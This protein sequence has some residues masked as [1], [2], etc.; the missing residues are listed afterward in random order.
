MATPDYDDDRPRP[1]AF[2]EAAKREGWGKLK[3]FLGA[4]PGVGKTYAM[5]E[6]AQVRRKEGVDLVVGVVETH[7]RAET[8]VLLQGLEVLPR[9]QLSYRGKI[10]GEMDLDALLKRKPKLALVD[11]LAHSNVPGSR[12][13]K[14]HQDVEELLAAGIDVYT[15]LNIQHLESLNDVVARIARIRVRETLPDKVLELADEIELI[16]LPPDD[17]LQRLREGKVYVRDQVGHAIRHFFSKGNLTAFRELSLRVAAERVDA[18]MLRYMRANAIPGPWPAQDRLLVCVNEAEVSKSL[19]RAARR[20]AERQRMPW[21]AIY[22]ETLDYPALSDELKGRIAAVLRLAEN[23]GG[24]TSTIHTGGRVADELL[25]YA[26]TRNISHILIGRPRRRKWPGWLRESVGDTILRTG[27]AFEITVIS[28]DREPEPIRAPA[29][30]AFKFRPHFG[31][32]G[33]AALAVF[34][35]S[36]LAFIADQYLPVANVALIYLAAVLV[37][38][39]RQGLG[40]S[41]FAGVLSFMICDYF[42]TDPRYTLTVNRKDE[43]LTLFLFLV[44]ATLAGDLA[45]RLKDQVEA[46]RQSTR[47]ITNLYDFSR[48]IAAAAT[49]DDVLWTS[50]HHVAST[51]R[52]RS[53][54]LLPNPEGRLGIV[55]GFPPEDQLE[56]KDWGAAEWAWEHQHPAGWDTETLPTANW[57]FYPFKTRRGYVG[58]LGISFDKRQRHSL[59]ED[60]FR[61]LEAIIDQMAIATERAR[62]VADLE[63]ARLASETEQLRSALL[64]SVSHDLRTPLVSMIGAATSLATY[65][66]VLAK[67]DHDQLVQTILDE[68]ERLNRNVQNLLDMTRLG[69]GSLELK[70][71]WTDP[72]VLAERAVK[73]L[74]TALERHKLVFDFAPGL[75]ALHVDMALITQVLVNLLEN[76][77]KFAPAATTITVAAHADPTEMVITVSDEGPGIPVEARDAAFDMF[78]RVRPSDRQGGTGLGLSICRGLVQAHGGH[79]L[80]KAGPN[81]RGTTIEFTLPLASPPAEA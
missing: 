42:F 37:V 41:I 9:R 20:M 71:E 62:L 50:V 21:V 34:Y 17:L 55:S 44:V 54:I 7:G 63:E 43:L 67:G 77:A 59:S 79:I 31:A 53:I 27:K 14:R 48:R 29:R 10:F 60:Q 1:E 33:K 52:C 69:Y 49:L 75:P 56:T 2:L 15:T 23:L 61:L 47:R 38:G 76:A 57:Y 58:L 70:R 65:G 39:A 13:T 11:E 80:A 73:Q 16:D 3:I 81:G 25:A 36:V 12:H 64:S 72:R 45:S 4:Y 78:Y 5:L 28:S 68:G 51:L 32:Y 19:V 30:A 26:R 18:Q 40:P 22:V 74:G 46:L 35:A 24:E 66:D 8:E 6:A